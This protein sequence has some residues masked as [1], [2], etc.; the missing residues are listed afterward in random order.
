MDAS[1]APAVLEKLDWMRNERIWPNGKRY[2]WT[3]A[4]GLVLLVSLHNELGEA[5]Y[6]E[7]AKQ[8]VADV[9]RRLGEPRG[10]RIGE[11]PHQQGQHY[12]YLAMWIYALAR[13]G[14]IEPEYHQRAITLAKEIHP[15]FVVPGVG[16]HWKMK[17]DLSEPYHGYGY[18]ALDSFHGWVVY[19]LLDSSQ[20]SEEIA[21]MQE[22]AVRSY[23]PLYVMQDLS[24]AMILWL[25]HFFP[26][27]EWART[28]R[29]RA[30]ITLERM[31]VDP[32]GYFC[33][34][35]L[36]PEVKFAFTNYGVSLGLQ[37]IDERPE[38]VERVHAFF[39]DYRSGD[40]YDSNAIT[41]VMACCA[42]HPGELIAR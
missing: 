3:D 14:A 27:E 7:Q 15:H 22:I 39:R 16:V 38:R 29:Q 41:H 35:P 36:L 42:W 11:E 13:L 32:P 25:A 31:W 24:L 17:N 37:A 26:R 23:L 2:L 12:H 9:E 28:L 21:Q 6:L 1:L 34:E 20:L 19:R 30:L 5:H 33:R 18:G 4:L 8:L 40:G 10:L